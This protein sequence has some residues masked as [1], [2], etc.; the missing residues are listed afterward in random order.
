MVDREGKEEDQ[1]GYWIF[2]HVNVFFYD[3]LSFVYFQL[4]PLLAS[5]HASLR[6]TW[7]PPNGD[8]TFLKLRQRINLSLL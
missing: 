7:G 3:C 1:G 5:A 2:I 8:H 6:A 4:L